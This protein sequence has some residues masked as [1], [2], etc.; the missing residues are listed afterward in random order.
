MVK[1][2]LFLF[3]KYKNGFNYAIIINKSACLK[4]NK[5]AAMERRKK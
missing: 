2:S 1:I 4:Y 3:L 5:I